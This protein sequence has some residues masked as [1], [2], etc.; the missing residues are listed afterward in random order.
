MQKHDRRKAAKEHVRQK[1]HEHTAPTP[2]L[3]HSAQP[4]D[5][6]GDA[7][8][9]DKTATIK[10]CCVSFKLSSP[11]SV[12]S[13]CKSV[14]ADNTGCGLL[15]AGIDVSET[16]KEFVAN[17]MDV[18]SDYLLQSVKSGNLR[19][20]SCCDEPP[21]LLAGD[22]D[23]MKPDRNQSNA[24]CSELMCDSIGLEHIDVAAHSNAD[25]Q[26][27]NHQYCKEVSTAT[28]DSINREHASSLCVSEKP[29]SQ[30]QSS[31]ITCSLNASQKLQSSSVRNASAMSVSSSGCELNFSLMDEELLAC[32]AHS[33]AF[34]CDYHSAEIDVCKKDIPEDVRC[35]T[36]SDDIAAVTSESVDSGDSS[37]VGED[38]AT[39]LCRSLAVVKIAV[40]E[41][42]KAGI[43]DFELPDSQYGEAIRLKETDKNSL[44]RTLDKDVVEEIACSAG[45]SNVSLPQSSNVSLPQSC[46]SAL[47]SACQQPSLQLQEKQWYAAIFCSII[48]LCYL[49]IIRCCYSFHH[50]LL[51]IG[52]KLI[53]NLI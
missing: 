43:T 29:D 24:V 41:S 52:N 32:F 23:L 20:E 39:V 3:M 46:H 31:L 45:S 16:N 19:P 36:E 4:T 33:D 13:S 38:D 34:P 12:C 10:K 21:E 35:G 27:D 47:A 2:R 48:P 50:Q 49:E 25:E 14:S 42:V 30:E 5:D 44:L 51:Y 7:G 17:T 9:H 37:V 26:P 6:G 28:S 40:A 22:A 8:F 18:Q 11:G 15:D 1:L 53:L